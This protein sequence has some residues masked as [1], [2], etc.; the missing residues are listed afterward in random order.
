MCVSLLHFQIRGPPER[1]MMCPRMNL[2][3]LMDTGWMFLGEGMEA[4]CGPQFTLAN[5]AAG[6]GEEELLSGKGNVMKLSRLLLDL[7]LNEIP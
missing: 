4:L 5:K 2:V 6:I 1:K 7:E 3:L